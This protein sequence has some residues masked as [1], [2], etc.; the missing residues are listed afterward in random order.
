MISGLKEVIF[1]QI[2]QI[3]SQ[4]QKRCSQNYSGGRHSGCDSWRMIVSILCKMS[5]KHKARQIDHYG[6][7]FP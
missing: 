2:V 5:W 7:Y 3:R 1:V 6:V 4:S